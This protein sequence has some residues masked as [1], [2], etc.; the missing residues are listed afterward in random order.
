MF[1]RT[2]QRCVHKKHGPRQQCKQ[3]YLN[4]T[5]ST[6]AF[7]QGLIFGRVRGVEPLPPPRAVYQPRASRHIPPKQFLP[8]PGI[9]GGASGAG[10]GLL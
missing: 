3:F 6:Y 2:Q 4:Q 5:L 7:S 1:T 8:P 9:A 10:H